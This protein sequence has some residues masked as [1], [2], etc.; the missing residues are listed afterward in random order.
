MD[1]DGDSQQPVINAL[2]L[3]GLICLLIF[4]WWWV[5]GQRCPPDWMEWPETVRGQEGSPTLNELTPTE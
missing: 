4:G 3:V 1:R 2:C 5:T